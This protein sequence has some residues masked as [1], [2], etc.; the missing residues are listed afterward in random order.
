[1]GPP[2]LEGP[3]GDTGT[4][5]PQGAKGD[6]GPGGPRGP[7]GDHGVA[8]LRTRRVTR[9]SCLGASGPPGPWG[10]Q[11]RREIRTCWIGGLAAPKGR[12]RRPRPGRAAGMKGDLGAAGPCGAQG[13][14]GASGPVG[15]QGPKGDPGVA[16]PPG[17]RGARGP[18][19]PPSLDLRVGIERG[20]A[21]REASEILISAYCV[22][23]IGDLHIVGT[24]GATCD[25]D[26]GTKAVGRRA[27]R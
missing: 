4:P 22:D 20:T 11:V 24:T 17:L 21:M 16:G 12:C 23:G 14:R 5:G 18:A 7:Q 2:G 6:P 3:K 13:L 15:P 9:G 19:G 26:P 10:F 8:E 27:R 25:G 1:M